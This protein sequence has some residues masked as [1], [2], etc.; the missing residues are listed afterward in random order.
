MIKNAP[1]N[2]H[3]GGNTRRYS[4][5]EYR[6]IKN[7]KGEITSYRIVVSSGFDCNGR[8]VKHKLPWKPECKMLECARMITL[9]SNDKKTTLTVTGQ[10]GIVQY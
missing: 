6:K 10:G 2:N 1:V 5:G 3:R 9:V 8:R 7:K 4:Y